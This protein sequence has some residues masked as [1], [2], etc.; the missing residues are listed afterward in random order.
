[1][2]RIW[3]ACTRQQELRDR[4]GD[5]YRGSPAFDLRWECHAG[6]CKDRTIRGMVAPTGT[7]LRR[8]IGTGKPLAGAGIR[9]MR[10][11]RSVLLRGDEYQALGLRALCKHASSRVRYFRLRAEFQLHQVL[12]RSGDRAQAT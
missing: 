3:D 11:E 4:P 7:V 10:P 8:G 2:G 5:D 6:L 9:L 12:R 1:M